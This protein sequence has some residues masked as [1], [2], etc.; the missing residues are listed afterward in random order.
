MVTPLL[1]VMAGNFTSSPV[2]VTRRSPIPEIPGIAGLYCQL[3]ILVA[4]HSQV[5]R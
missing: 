2:T 3:A 1:W 4:E 5:D